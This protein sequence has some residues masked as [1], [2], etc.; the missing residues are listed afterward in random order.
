MSEIVT[1]EIKSVSRNCQEITCV[2]NTRL[3]N[4]NHDGYM[5]VEIKKCEINEVK[6]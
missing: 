6:I 5:L 1:C 2:E 3:N 4:V